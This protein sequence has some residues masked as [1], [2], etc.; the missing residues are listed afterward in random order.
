V[1]R[2]RSRPHTTYVRKAKREFDHGPSGFRGKTLATCGLRQAVQPGRMDFLAGGRSLHQTW[3]LN[4]LRATVT[5]IANQVLAQ[6]F[7]LG[8]YSMRSIA[9]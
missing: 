7:V 8:M 4:S 3:P 5:G 9:K 6:A 2:C 1:V